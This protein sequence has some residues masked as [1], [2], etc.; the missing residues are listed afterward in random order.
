MPTEAQIQAAATANEA[1]RDTILAT[2]AT[3]TREGYT[4]RALAV[5]L[6]PLGY[7]LTDPE[8][9]T[10]LAYLT[11]KKFVDE[12]KSEISATLRYRLTPAGC[13]RCELLGLIV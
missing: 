12:T 2:L 3:A 8:L 6:I 9:H 13:D 4:P 1:R 7:R 10:D 11:G 5:Q